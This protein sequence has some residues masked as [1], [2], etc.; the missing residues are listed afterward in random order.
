MVT[1]SECGRGA[2]VAEVVQ[3]S[4][5]DLVASC[6]AVGTLLLKVTYDP[7]WQVTVDGKPVE[8]FMLSP[9]YVGVAV[10]AGTHNVSARYVPV[11]TKT[12]LLLSGALLLVAAVPLARRLRG[13]R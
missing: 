2:A 3:A 10:P 13:A 12:P 6:D 4:R 5:L 11:S 7:G 8:T 1:P 9:A